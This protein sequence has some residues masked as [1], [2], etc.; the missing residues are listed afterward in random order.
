MGPVKVGG[1]LTLA[2]GAR[3]RSEWQAGDPFLAALEDRLRAGRLNEPAILTI[4]RN[5]KRRRFAG[6]SVLRFER[7]WLSATADPRPPIDPRGKWVK[8]DVEAFRERRRYG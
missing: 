7:I 8:S 6:F 5:A 2:P 3:I 1:R 4:F